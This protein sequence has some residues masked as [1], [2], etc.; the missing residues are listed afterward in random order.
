MKRIFVA[1]AVIFCSL[2][3]LA[4][5]DVIFVKGNP[6]IIEESKNCAVEVTFKNLSIEGKPYMQYLKERGEQNVADWDTDIKAAIDEFVKEFN[7]DNKKGLKVN[8]GQAA[9]SDYR[10]VIDLKKMDLGSGAASVLIGFGAGGVRMY[11]DITVY[12]GKNP[13]AVL[14][15]DGVNGGSGYTESKRLRDAFEEMAEDTVK[16]LKKVCK[17]SK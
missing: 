14:K 16:T 17:S 5:S 11:C 12:E 4:G 6:C 13:V 9:K 1:I 2:N 8:R 3:M 10:M 15:G 7:S